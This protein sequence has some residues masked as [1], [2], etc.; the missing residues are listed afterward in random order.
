V[1]VSGVRWRDK[2]AVVQEK[3]NFER[4]GVRAINRAVCRNASEA[5]R[6]KDR[7]GCNIASAAV[8]QMEGS[9]TSP[10][11]WINSCLGR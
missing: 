5:Q 7:Q 2:R 9:A 8:N 10:E 11:A 1:Y 4:G 3:C 6:G